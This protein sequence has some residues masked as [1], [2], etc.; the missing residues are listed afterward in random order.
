MCV[1]PHLNCVGIHPRMR[2]MAHSEITFTRHIRK[3]FNGGR[4]HRYN[5]FCRTFSEWTCNVWIRMIICCFTFQYFPSATLLIMV[6]IFIHTIPTTTRWESC[7]ICMPSD[8]DLEFHMDI[9]SILLTWEIL[10][11]FTYHQSWTGVMV[12]PLETSIAI[13]IKQVPRLPKYS[14]TRFPTNTFW[15]LKGLTSLKKMIM[16]QGYNSLG[17]SNIFIWLNF[18][19]VF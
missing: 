19:S 17:A 15:K 6:L 10:L 11:V 3:I 8:C 12:I 5:I 14:S 13:G 16:P 1:W 2:V 7:Q 9:N 4:R 18:C